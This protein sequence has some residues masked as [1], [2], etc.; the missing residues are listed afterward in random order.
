MRRLGRSPH[1]LAV[2]GWDCRLSPVPCSQRGVRRS[3]SASDSRSE[4]WEFESLCPHVAAC[5]RFAD[6]ELVSG[7]RGDAFLWARV[8]ARL[9]REV[10]GSNATGGFCVF[11]LGQ[12]IRSG[13]QRCNCFTPRPCRRQILIVKAFDI[14]E[15]GFD[16]RTFGLGAQHAN[17]CATPL[18]MQ[19]SLR[20]KSCADF[21]RRRARQL[22]SYTQRPQ[23][24]N[25]SAAGN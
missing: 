3:G 5:P 13:L 1:C 2:A 20:N 4:G 16:P 12:Y 11:V 24:K 17:H 23:L 8:W 7:R 25:S 9:W 10:V 6:A 21:L 14:A 18:Q 22:F 15:R 19:S